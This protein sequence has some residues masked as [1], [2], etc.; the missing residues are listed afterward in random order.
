MFDFLNCDCEKEIIDL[1]K[2][3]EE[4][5]KRIKIL[6][7]D[8]IERRR[9][10]AKKSKRSKI[11]KWLPEHGDI[12]YVVWEMDGL[13]PIIPIEMKETWT[14]REEDFKNYYSRRIFPTRDDAQEYIDKL[15]K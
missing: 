7:E 9:Q 5:D 2:K 11:N 8:K 14:D 1:T 12:Y 10:E 6:E 4:Q 3:L 15:E 13:T